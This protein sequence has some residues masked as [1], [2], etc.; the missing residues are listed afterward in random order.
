MYPKKTLSLAIAALS[1]CMA[2][3]AAYNVTGKLDNNG[4]SRIFL[5]TQTG[6]NTMDT[7]ATSLTPD[8]S[9][10]FT[11]NISA[12]MAAEIRSAGSYLH[13]PVMLEDGKSYKVT[14]DAST[15]NKWTIDG[16]GDLQNVRNRFH[17]I[18]LE[19]TRRCDSIQHYYRST[20]DLNDYFWVVQLKG[21]L[22]RE[23]EAFDAKRDSFAMANDN[24]VSAAVLAS[25]VRKLINNKT[26]H[27]KYRLL[28][29]NA[30]NTVPGNILKVEAERMAQI[31]VGDRKSVV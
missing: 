15:P 26:V 30:R 4:G 14:G 17:E 10:T 19:H 12:P 7:I 1:G 11:G 8:G 28:G 22:Q 5:V 2:L 6:K 23:G 20:Y 18:E 13:V 24:L 29:N 31:V 9:F 21:A 25:D 27:Q 16:G 3:S